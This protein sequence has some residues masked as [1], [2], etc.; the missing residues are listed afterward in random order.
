MKWKW[1][2]KSDSDHE[3]L[4]AVTPQ[5]GDYAFACIATA[6]NSRPDLIDCDLQGQLS[7][8]NTTVKQLSSQHN[9]KNTSAITVMPPGSFDMFL[10]EAPQVPMNEM[11]DAVRWQISDR[12]AYSPEEAIIQTIEIPGQTERGRMP[13]VYVV[14]A[15]RERVK[16]QINLLESNGIDLQYIDIPE[17]AQRNIAM[18][19]P[20]DSVGV[21]MLRLEES[22]G[23]LTITHESDLYLARNIDSGYSGLIEKP[24]LVQTEQTGLQLEE[25]GSRLDNAYDQIVLE[26]QRSLD[27]YESHFSKLPI[28]SLVIAPLTVEIPGIEEKL[29]ELLGIQVRELDLNEIVQPQVPLDRD[30]QAGCFT[31]I[32]AAMRWNANLASV[33]RL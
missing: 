27:Y 26:I 30:K 12:I 31:A 1:W 17:L 13:M 25:S 5:G 28:G 23:M 3:S 9:V 11:N 14:A 32:G 6:E 4:L 33:R 2:N 21:A 16:Q 18:F 29:S 15:E 10:M 20:E 8:P 24:V 19:C 22:Q 7:D